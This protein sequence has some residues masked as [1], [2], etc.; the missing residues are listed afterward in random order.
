MFV[1]Q[2]ISIP[3]N[4]NS[5]ISIYF[6]KRYSFHLSNIKFFRLFSFIRKIVKVSKYIHIFLSFFIYILLQFQISHNSQNVFLK[7]I[8]I[9]FILGEFISPMHSHML[10]DVKCLQ[11]S[12][13]VDIGILS[14]LIDNIRCNHVDN[15][16]NSVS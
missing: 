8:T 13:V 14:A 10:N 4:S 6:F 7:Y 5:L 15:F 12:R 11:T 3:A 2:L 9:L 16:L 1:N